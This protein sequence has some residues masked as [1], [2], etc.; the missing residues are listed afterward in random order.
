MILGYIPSLRGIG[1]SEKFGSFQLGI[2]SAFKPE[3]QGLGLGL[4]GLGVYG[5]GVLG[6]RV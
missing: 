3:V 2:S 5:F 4:R 1:L 6:F